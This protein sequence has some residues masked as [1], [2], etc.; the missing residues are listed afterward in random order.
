MIKIQKEDYRIIAWT[1]GWLIVGLII[2]YS[3]RSQFK[4]IHNEE[5][6]NKALIIVFN[7]RTDN[8]LDKYPCLEYS[9][10]QKVIFIQGYNQRIKDSQDE[11]NAFKL[12]LSD[13][14]HKKNYKPESFK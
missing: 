1:C 10:A 14:F 4:S 11:V 5:L 2:G 3:V 12:K 9:D 7:E 8:L 6:T 13:E